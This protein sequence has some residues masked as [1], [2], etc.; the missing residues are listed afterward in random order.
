MQPFFILLLSMAKTPLQIIAD[1]ERALKAKQKQILDEIDRLY[2]QFINAVTPLAASQVMPIGVFELS[3]LPMLNNRIDQLI[4]QL[5]KGMEIV[6]RS[7]IRDSW[8]LSNQANNMIADIRLDQ[9]LI[10]KDAQVAFYDPNREALNQFLARK[11]QGLG[12][13]ERIYNANEQFKAEL[14]AGLGLGISK[15][16]SAAEMGR[17]LRQYLQDP[18]KLFRRVR[19]AEGNLKLSKNAKAFNPGQGKY[20]SA[21]KNIERLTITETNMALRKNDNIRFQNSP[22]ILGYEIRLSAVH[23][24]CDMCDSMAG[25]YPVGFL[26]IGWHPHCLCFIV[27]I[28]MSDKQFMAYQQLVLMGEDT[29]ANIHKIAPRVKEIP[30]LAGG[31]MEAN[32]E[33]LGRLKS[34]PYWYRDNPDYVPELPTSTE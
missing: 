5:N 9:S 17:D 10:P 24:Q 12:L 14:E 21:R 6:I 7:G 31:W 34:T 23:E 22:F 4:T 30:T 27:P 3:K 13:S 28:L 1:K 26:F 2:N 20:R 19:D 8:N 25:E 33:A 18:D 29:E 32:K 16:Q 11:E 15:G